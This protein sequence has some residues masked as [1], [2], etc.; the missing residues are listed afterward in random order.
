MGKLKRQ[1]KKIKKWRDG[2]I[3]FSYLSIEGYQYI[4]STYVEGIASGL[5][6]EIN[7]E[8]IN[9]LIPLFNQKEGL[10]SPLQ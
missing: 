2:Y 8:I 5:I 6:T 4:K 3:D 1:R 9:K 10:F 7:I